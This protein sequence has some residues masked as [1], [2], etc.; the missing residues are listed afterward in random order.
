[1]VLLL[2][3]V[4]HELETA[5]QNVSPPLASPSGP[6]STPLE[7][8]EVTI[9]VQYV[10]SKNPLT[11]CVEIKPLASNKEARKHIHAFDVVLI[12]NKKLERGWDSGE[13][14][15]LVFSL[16]IVKEDV[17]QGPG[18]DP[19]PGYVLA[20]VL[21][22]GVFDALKKSPG[23][24][25]YV[26]GLG[27]YRESTGWKK[28]SVAPA[29]RAYLALQKCLEHDAKPVRTPSS[30]IMLQVLK[31]PGQ[32]LQSESVSLASDLF[33]RECSDLNPSQTDAVVAVLSAIQQGQH[34]IHLIQGP[35]GTG[36]RNGCR[37]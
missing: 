9:K 14:P 6:P 16:A 15:G 31:G 24:T 4:R 26:T 19:V 28:M 2:E 23:Q 37:D 22:E 12:S 20:N 17:D 18:R 13:Q 29:S 10:Y 25:W 33:E 35:P 1:M 36:E 5:L 27:E 11:I 21:R 8:S 3:E 7:I 34:K 32:L 30:P